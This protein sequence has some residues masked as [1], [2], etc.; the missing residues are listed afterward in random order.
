MRA[1]LGILAALLAVCA[2]C[3]REIQL[4][5]WDEFNAA[6]LFQGYRAENVRL[7]PDGDIVLDERKTKG[8]ATGVVETDVIDLLDPDCST[9]APQAGIAGYEITCWGSS[10]QASGLELYTRTGDSYFSREGWSDWDKA[11][12]LT[13]ELPR[14]SGRYLQVRVVLAADRPENSPRLSGLDLKGSYSLPSS[15]QALAL[16]PDSF[17]NPRIVT[18]PVEF[19]YERPDQPQIAGLVERNRLTALVAGCTSELDT[20]VTLLHWMGHTRNTRN[21]FA[22]SPDY[23]WDL[24]KIVSYGAEGEL[25]IEGHCL[26]YAIVYISALT[27]LGFQARHWADQGF[28]FADHEVV[29]VWSN[30]LGRWLYMDPSLCHYYTDKSSG[31][32]LSILELHRVFVDTFLRE[33]ETLRLPMETMRARVAAI[34][35]KNVPIDYVS[36]DYAYGKPNPDYDWGWF[37]GYL[38]AGFMRLTTRNDFHSHPEPWFPHFGEGVQDFDE[39][40][41][42][43]DPKT[44]APE[45]VSRFSGR[46]RD[47][48]WTLNQAQIKAVQTSARTV[49]CEFGRSMPFFASFR[50][51]VDDSEPFES[52]SSYV[53]NLR[54]GRNKLTVIPVNQWGRTGIG[55]AITATVR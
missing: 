50:V 22:S 49:A 25:S 37:H 41:S 19:G 2:A 43:S 32:P 7:S 45:K 14:G 33:G 12:G 4:E 52:G 10:P 28:R 18:S 53:W 15:I 38:A 24:S 13:A 31:A 3:R 39:F 40:L 47:F 30:S 1:M 34:G 35:G 11:D 21:G 36:C 20:L 9:V 5:K 44:P 55:A 17:I 26:S 48:Y 42:W 29:E 8:V 51:T 54:P 6:R 23:P 46:E 27:G 16:Q